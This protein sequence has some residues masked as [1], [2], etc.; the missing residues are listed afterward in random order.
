MSFQKV[1]LSFFIPTRMCTTS[2]VYIH[3]STSTGGGEGDYSPPYLGGRKGNSAFPHLLFHLSPVPTKITINTSI[4]ILGNSM[5][6]THP[7]RWLFSFQEKHSYLLV[8]PLCQ[9]E[10][11]KYLFQL[12]IPQQG[13]PEMIY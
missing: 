1:L 13:C 5:L 8:D 11:R 9:K 7:S 4:I 6:F 2:V 12:S 10:H 3:S